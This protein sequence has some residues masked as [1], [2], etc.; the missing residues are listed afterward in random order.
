MVWGWSGLLE[1]SQFL[2]V[3][4]VKEVRDALGHTPTF[5]IQ[6]IAQCHRRTTTNV[7]YVVLRNDGAVPSTPAATVGERCLACF[8]CNLVYYCAWCTIPGFQDVKYAI[9]TK[10]LK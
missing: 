8:A 9:V 5:V 1:C 4:W 10:Q 2:K 6:V 3:L 7:A